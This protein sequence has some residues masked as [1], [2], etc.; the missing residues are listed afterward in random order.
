VATVNEVFSPA[1]EDVDLAKRI[2]K[3]YEEARTKGLGATTLG[4]KMIDYGSFKRA[5][6]LLSLA[7]AIEERT[8][9]GA[10]T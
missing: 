8:K 10:S 1:K 4:G 2:V 6:A 9:G 5:E 7:G 3:A